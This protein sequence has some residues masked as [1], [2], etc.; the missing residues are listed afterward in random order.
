MDLIKQATRIVEEVRPLL[1]DHFYMVAI[2][3][4]VIITGPNPGDLDIISMGNYE[5]FETRRM[6]VYDH[7]QDLVQESTTEKCLA[8]ELRR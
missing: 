8:L 2:E 1:P 3:S 6:E 4:T 7:A 5:D